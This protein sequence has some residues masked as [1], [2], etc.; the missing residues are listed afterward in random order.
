MKI[1]VPVSASIPQMWWNINR[2]GLIFYKNRMW[3]YNLSYIAGWQLNPIQLCL[4]VTV[5]TVPNNIH[6][7]TIHLRDEVH[8]QLHCDDRNAILYVLSEV[9]C[10]HVLVR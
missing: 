1:P 7:Y 8:S 5:F 2:M 6:G 3:A 10:L 4:I 9:I